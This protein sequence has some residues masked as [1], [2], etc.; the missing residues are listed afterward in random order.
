MSISSV[1]ANLVRLMTIPL[2]ISHRNVRSYES[3]IKASVGEY[4]NG[5]FTSIRSMRGYMVKL[6]NLSLNTSH[7]LLHK[8]GGFA[9]F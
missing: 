6:L 2:N 7:G 1:E 9:I 8:R 4:F 3:L 5:V